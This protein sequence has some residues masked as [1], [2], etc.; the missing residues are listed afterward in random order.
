MTLPEYVDQTGTA[1]AGTTRGIPAAGAARVMSPSEA[2]ALAST[3][4]RAVTTVIEGKVAEI[5]LALTVLLAGG[6]L[7]VEDVPGVGKTALATSLAKAIS[8]HVNR[9]QF[10]PDLLPSDV[11]G[12]GVLTGT[13]RT[14]EFQPGPVF[15]NIVVADEIN[16]ASPKTQSALLEAMAERHVTVDGVT[17]DLP[18]PFIVLATQNPFDMEGTFILPEAQRDRFMVRMSMGYPSREA[19]L[20]MVQRRERTD[21]AAALRPVASIDDVRTM[22][23]AVGAM[24]VAPSVEQYAVDLVRAT[25]EHER[26]RVGASPRATLHLIRAAKAWALLRGREFVVPD[27]IARLAV[28]VLAHRLSLMGHSRGQADAEAVVHRIAAT[29]PAPTGV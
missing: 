4:E 15:A 22:C 25:R 12:S 10:T 11:T 2:S 19:E 1:D 21:P 23:A 7:L 20:A 28:P 13:S 9:I 26:V 29:V 16:R 14:F 18:D 6:H 24:Y 27:D 8:A 17:H 3:I 5:R